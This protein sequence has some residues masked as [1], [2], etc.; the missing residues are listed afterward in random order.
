MRYIGVD[1][2]EITPTVEYYAY[3]A[4]RKNYELVAGK[5]LILISDVS[6]TDENKRLIR[7][8]IVNDHFVNFELI[9]QGYANSVSQ[10]PD[11]ACTEMFNSAQGEAAFGLT[12]FWKPTPT[13]V[14][15][16][17]YAPPPLSTSTK[18]SG[19]GGGDN[20][21]CDASY[22]TVCIPP[23]PPDLDC[24]D[25]PYRNFTVRGPDPHRF[26]GDHDGVGCER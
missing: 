26:D 2:P 25:I 4:T 9:S 18:G 10:P 13:Y 20:S 14:P 1:A 7:Y 15:T 21:R 16:A 23:P 3:E 19:S 8:V 5:T 17:T 24:K 12:G 6:E 22:P 11:I